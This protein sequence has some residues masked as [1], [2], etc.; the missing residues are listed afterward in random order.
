MAKEDSQLLVLKR[1]E[2]E[3]E[4][5]AAMDLQSAQSFLQA[6]QAKLKE[7]QSYKL[8]YLKRMQQMGSSGMGG[9]SYQHYQRFI[10]QLDQGILA[11]TNV[12]STAK[13]VVEQRRQEWLMQTNKVKAVDTLLDKKAQARQAKLDKYEQNQADEFAAQ[14]YIRSQLG[15]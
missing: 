15:V 9:G 3:K 11:Q 7:V 12:V 4:Q 5:K 6:N 14:K 13:E 8:D 10:V 1:I 2:K